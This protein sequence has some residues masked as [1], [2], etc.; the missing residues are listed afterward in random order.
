MKCVFGLLS[1]LF[2]TGC[3]SSIELNDRAFVRMAVLDKTQ[4]GLELSLDFTLPSRLIPGSAGGGGGEQ[5]GKPY[6][7]ISNTGKDFGEAYRKI[8]SDLSRKI[9][10][11]QTRAI[12]IG[13]QLAEEGIEPILDF[14][15]R[16]P[17]IHMNAYLFVTPGKAKE[18]EKI[19]AIM[20]RFPTDILVGYANSRVTVDTTIKD[21]LMLNYTGGDII[22][23]ILKF[24]RTRIESEKE[25][26]QTW[27]GTSGA[28]IFKQGKMVGTLN[29]SEMRGGLW[30]LGKLKDAEISVP[31]PTDGKD[32]SFMIKNLHT[33]IIPKVREDQ[34]E[35]FIKCKAEAEVLS[36]NSNIN[37]LDSKQLNKLGKSLDMKVNER[38]IRTIDK[39]KKVQSDPFRIGEYIDWNYPGKWKNMKP[40][41]R[42]LYSSI[43]VEMQTSI[44]V[45]Q[46]GTYRHDVHVT[47]DPLNE[48]E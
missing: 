36:S 8:Q 20:E 5:A 41:W 6:T 40:R 13:R 24:G 9:S 21:F 2:L 17:T 44:K 31:S 7:Y 39:T 15:A 47:T 3:W 42:A 33:H 46:V 32:I 26:E 37:L 34:V 27:M 29:T 10:F 19:S 35:I 25:K 28:A 4:S 30:I 1:L 23:P 16:E 38:M 12:I 14:L 18:I 45:K 11:G 43:K 48:V 22:L